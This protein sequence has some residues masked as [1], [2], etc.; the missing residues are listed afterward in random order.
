[1]LKRIVGL[2]GAVAAPEANAETGTT[3]ARCDTSGRVLDGYGAF[4][5]PPPTA[6]PIPS[7]LLRPRH[8]TIRRTTARR[9][10]VAVNT[11]AR[12]TGWRDR[13][14]PAQCP[15]RIIPHQRAAGSARPDLLVARAVADP[16]AGGVLA[17][18]RPLPADAA[19]GHG[20]LDPWSRSSPHPSAPCLR[21]RQ[22]SPR[23]M[24]RAINSPPNRPSRP[25]LPMS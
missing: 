14:R 16:D 6:R 2:S 7:Y 21:P 11:L 8:R 13:L 23:P 5:P 24:R 9:K 15:R 10:V 3:S 18:R 20:R 17:R 12:R 22:L 25:I 19:A 4:E 1:M